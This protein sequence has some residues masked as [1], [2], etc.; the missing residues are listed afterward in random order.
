MNLHARNIA[1]SGGVPTHL[2]EEAT[3][4]MKSRG[5]MNVDTAKTYLSA[6]CLFEEVRSDERD[7]KSKSE[8]ASVT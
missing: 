8:M 2:V 5:K 6:H 4:F 7:N 1:I 3:R